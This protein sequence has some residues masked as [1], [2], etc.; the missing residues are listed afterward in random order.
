MVARL[1]EARSLS[2]RKPQTLTKAG[3]CVSKKD[4]LSWFTRLEKA[5]LREDI[6][7]LL[8]DPSRVYNADEIFFLMNPSKGKVFA[9]RGTK[10]VFEVMKN[11]KEGLTVM[12]LVRAD[13]Q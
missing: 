7:E 12:L 3:S 1:Q 6:Q 2:V 9:V 4:V 8:D 5:L 10:N 11:E 13:A